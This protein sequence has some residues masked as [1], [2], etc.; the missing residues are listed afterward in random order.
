MASKNTVWVRGLGPLSCVLIYVWGLHFHRTLLSWVWSS[1]RGV[2]K[3]VL[4]KALFGKLA[5][6]IITLPCLITEKV[7]RK[8]IDSGAVLKHFISTREKT[9]QNSPPHSYNGAHSLELLYSR[10][11]CFREVAIVYRSTPI[12]C[13]EDNTTW[14]TS[15]VGCA[16]GTSDNLRRVDAEVLKKH[17][18]V[19]C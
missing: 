11:W 3:H 5:D 6:T 15:D 10:K 16:Q 13:Y 1:V 2:S 7:Q 14:E 12:R 18:V 19:S 17:N 4:C 8:L 9:Y